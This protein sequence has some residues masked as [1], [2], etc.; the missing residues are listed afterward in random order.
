MSATDSFLK[1]L[2]LIP[3]MDDDASPAPI[4]SFNTARG[5]TVAVTGI[6][7][8]ALVAQITSAA[9]RSLKHVVGKWTV[10]LA[11][12]GGRGEWRMEL[13]GTSGVHLW[14]FSSRAD[15]LPEGTAQKLSAFLKRA[16]AGRHP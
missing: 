15:A 13:R 11:S 2:R 1:S 4:L 12:T 7:D 5:V 8:A 6:T 10:S 9:K 16:A 14:V 3:P